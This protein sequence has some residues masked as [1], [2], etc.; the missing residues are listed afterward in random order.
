MGGRTTTTHR[1]TPSVEQRQ[2]N[3]ELL[4]YL[5]KLLLQ[6]G[7]KA[8]VSETLVHTSQNHFGTLARTQSWKPCPSFL[9]PA[10]P[11]LSTP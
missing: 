10:R 5:G 3:L 7:P 1:S 4:S 9:A 11:F 8:M 2:P 6:E